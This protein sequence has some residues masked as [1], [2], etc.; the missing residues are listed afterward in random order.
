MMKRKVRVLI[1][2]KNQLPENESLS[3]TIQ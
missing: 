2:P 1:D 3:S